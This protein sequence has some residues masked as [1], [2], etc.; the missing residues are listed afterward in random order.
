MWTLAPIQNFAGE[1][2]MSFKAFPPERGLSLSVGE[3]F[4]TAQEQAKSLGSN[5][6]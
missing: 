6:G 4:G 2:L 1:F 5:P 3:A